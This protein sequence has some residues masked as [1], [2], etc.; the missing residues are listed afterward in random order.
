MGVARCIQC[1]SQ[2]VQC[3]RRI[4]QRYGLHTGIMAEC[5]YI[6]GRLHRAAVPLHQ[7]LDRCLHAFLIVTEL[8]GPVKNFV[9]KGTIRYE[10]RPAMGR[11]IPL[12]GQFYAFINQAQRNQVSILADKRKADSSQAEIAALNQKNTALEQQIAKLEAVTGSV[13]LTTVPTRVNPE[14][15][16]LPESVNLTVQCAAKT[17]VLENLNFPNTTTFPWSMASCSDTVLTIH[18]EDSVLVKQWSGA[19]GFISFLRDF[20]NGQHRYV[21]ADFPDGARSMEAAAIDFILVSYRMR[22]QSSLLQSFQEADHLISQLEE[23]KAKI[24]ALNPG[25]DQSGSLAPS[26]SMP[27]VPDRIASLCMGPA[28]AAAPVYQTDAGSVKETTKAPPAR[29]SK[30]TVPAKQ[31]SGKTA[32][33]GQ[34][35]VQVGVFEQPEAVRST[36]SGNGYS[37]VEVAIQLKGKTYASIVV[38]GYESRAMA[39]QAAQR[40]GGMLKLVPQVVRHEP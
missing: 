19:R 8:E 14:A 9:D 21:P 36:L 25:N 39:E 18:T 5:P 40:I 24:N 2:R 22:G 31:K 4:D 17:L 26:P 11:S 1:G 28:H 29:P 16:A 15:R 38:R 32:V 10:P 23:N 30:T 37:V 20:S 7:L 13:T 3:G 35:S 33:P 27:H 12:N 6:R 34:F